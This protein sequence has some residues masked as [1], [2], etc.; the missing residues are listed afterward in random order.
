MIAFF[1]QNALLIFLT[2]TDT[3]DRL[4][5]MTFF[6]MAL[7]IQQQIAENIKKS[8]KIL[9]VFPKFSSGDHIGSAI[10]LAL[11]LQKLHKN[12]TVASD[13]FVVTSKYKFLPQIDQIL[14]TLSNPKKLVIQL[15]V[16]KTKV[17]DFRY[18][19]KDDTL[20]IY[21][22]PEE[23]TFQQEDVT[24]S[25]VSKSFDT[26]FVL[27]AT[28][29]DALG[30]I[31]ESNRD[32]FFDTPLINIDNSSHNENFGQMNLVDVTATSTAEVL[33]ELLKTLNIKLIDEEVGTALLT[34]I[35]SATKA[36]RSAKV[37]PKTLQIAGTL[38]ENKARRE[39]IVSNLYYN[40]VLST[41]RIW[42]LMLS[43]LKHDLNKRMIWTVIRE[44]DFEQTKTSPE[45]L[46]DIFEELISNIPG[47]QISFIVYEETGVPKAYVYSFLEQDLLQLMEKFHPEGT[48]QLA[49]LE[50]KGKKSAEAEQELIQT[51][52]EILSE[53]RQIAA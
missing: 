47:T 53:E 18:D 51:V 6:S 28:N 49:R 7:T 9:I 43:Q 42:G 44:Q 22:T 33:F 36:F 31:Y 10:G 26:I 52:K 50:F 27:G 16:S 23:G 35:I 34:G 14:G 13:G 4:L 32:F 8:E 17:S 1:P 48:S 38:V 37:T 19:M 15:D 30:E 20:N 45:K 3:I 39:E 5:T 21:V 25:A 2:K 11:A 40:R 41:L 24:V 12:V 46:P 29:L